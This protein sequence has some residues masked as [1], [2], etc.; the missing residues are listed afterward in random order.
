[1]TRKTLGSLLAAGV[2]VTLPRAAVLAGHLSATDSVSINVISVSGCGPQSM[3]FSGTATYSD[4]TQ[5]FLVMLDGTELLHSHKEK[6]AAWSTSALTVGTGSHTLTATI[7][8]HLSH[9][10]VVATQSRSF[11]VPV[12]GASSP[13][14]APTVSAGT[15]GG[16]S[17]C[18]PGTDQELQQPAQ[19]TVKGKV[20]G[21]AVTVK[22]QA[23]KKLPARLNPVNDLFRKVYGRDPVF[24]E[25]EYW[26]RR[27]WGDKPQYDALFGAMQWHKHLGHTTGGPH[28][29]PYKVLTR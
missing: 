3:T 23:V 29:T 16:S 19:K 6:V 4:P 17:D 13:T 27:Q 5:H 26:A 2:L 28:P 1:M 18:C 9:D 12:C 15:S 20:K 8:G 7:Y 25:W 11:S 21:A 24:A 10:D 14:P 22:K